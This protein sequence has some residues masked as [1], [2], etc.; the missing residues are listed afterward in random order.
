MLRTLCAAHPADWERRVP[1]AVWAWRTTPQPSLGNLSP[2]RIVTGLEPRTPFSFSALPVGRRPIPATDYVEE[3][4]QV[5]ESTHEYVR[6]FKQQRADEKESLV[7]RRS[8]TSS[9]QVGDFVLIL[10][11]EFM[12]QKTRPGSVS[13]KLMHR[14][15]DEV[16]QIHNKVSDSAV[17]VRTA[18]TG[19]DPTDFSNP[20]N[21]ERLIPA[22]TWQVTEPAGTVL[23]RIEILQ[24]DEVTFRP[25]TVIGYG[26]G[27]VVRLRFDNDLSEEWI[28]L[29]KE[30]YRWIV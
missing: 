6:R 16:F 22:V 1:L 5:Y 29:T 14:V 21:M 20:V 23:K 15:Y 12:G 26:Y 17:V 13:K 30:Q 25:G 19:A 9:V 4:A 18:A 8:R 27:G 11:P 24:P 28:D 10:R 3:L 7:A 2:Y